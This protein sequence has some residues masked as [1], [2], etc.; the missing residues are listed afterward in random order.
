MKAKKMK[1]PAPRN[2]MTG[3]KFSVTILTDHKNI[4]VKTIFRDPATGEI[5]S[6]GASHSSTWFTHR[7]EHFDTFEVLLRIKQSIT[8]H[9]FYI[10]AQ[11]SDQPEA[12]EGVRANYTDNPAPGV[13]VFFKDAFA[14][15]LT[16]DIDDNDATLIPE[17]MSWETTPVET[18]AEAVWAKVREKS[19]Y[20]KTAGCVWSTSG[21]AGF[22]GK[23]KFHFIVILANPLLQHDRKA[24]LETI[25]DADDAMGGAVQKHYW[26]PR[27][28]K[29]GIEDPL[30]PQVT[31]GI[32]LGDFVW[33]PPTPVPTPSPYAIPYS[34]TNKTTEFGREKL[35]G[36]CAWV[37]ATTSESHDRH[38]NVVKA[39]RLIGGYISG[40]EIANADGYAGLTNAVAGFKDPRHHHKTIAIRIPHGMNTP[41]CSV[42]VWAD[43]VLSKDFDNRELAEMLA[44]FDEGERQLFWDVSWEKSRGSKEQGKVIEGHLTAILG[45]QEVERGRGIYAQSIAT[46]HLSNYRF[47]EDG[48]KGDPVMVHIHTG[49]KVSASSWARM[50]SRDGKIPVPVGEKQP[51]LRKMTD[52]YWDDQLR[53][54]YDAMTFHPASGLDVREGNRLLLNVYRPT[55]SMPSTAV[56][57]SENPFLALL[58]ANLPN[59][60][61]INGQQQW[62]ANVLLDALAWA[63][64]RP[65]E[66]I[67]WAPVMQGWEGCGK[68]VLIPNT[69]RH[70]CGRNVGSS[71]PTALGSDFNGETAN[72][73][74]MIVAEMGERTRHSR[75]D[76]QEHLKEEITDDFRDVIA[77]GFDPKPTR[78]FASWFIMTNHKTS[79]LTNDGKAGRRY[80][81][82]I[83]ALQSQADVDRALPSSMWN[84]FPV[85]RALVS[86]PRASWFG[87]Y[88]V[89]WNQCGGAEQ[90][91]AMLEQ[92][93]LSHVS[94]TAPITSGRVEAEAE[95]M[96][97]LAA[98]IKQNI[99]DGA[100][101]FC[102]GFV[103]DTAITEAAQ[104]DPTL[105][106]A[107]SGKNIG[108][109]MKALGYSNAGRLNA[110]SDDKLL[111]P[112]TGKD[113]G[114]K[115]A[116]YVQ[117]ASLV[118]QS[119][120]Q[121]RC[122]LDAAQVDA[123]REAFGSTMDDTTSTFPAPRMT[124]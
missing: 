117:D 19:G 66:L 31:S 97:P 104:D 63:V 100:V 81:H 44:T 59:S 90:V 103:Y 88:M 22:S 10:H 74:V 122:L 92:R 53:V 120:A 5:D 24:L 36:I 50:P 60:I 47:V 20:T 33:Y 111:F 93:D 6:V 25:P 51:R 28:I 41:L 113:R 91:R 56:W 67:R 76:I 18:L 29:D 112:R 82:L 39:S 110:S 52:V 16:I 86:N 123:R 109:T 32:I 107:A 75:K 7:Q 80:A 94:H 61:E 11:R 49:S 105:K 85:V 78:N 115:V 99:E 95:G 45:E 102:G 64:Q 69:L 55:H 3:N 21:S 119:P 48:G 106:F 101:G 43:E 27:V 121:L 15:C 23:G 89:W 42:T 34:P 83:S 108:T 96:L 40:G 30:A 26:G 38:I 79:M 114:G 62:D 116:L 17:G 71:T 57:Y 98:M 35:A 2:L 84:T 13:Q 12:P 54:S 1:M 46:G 124:H 77:K 65:A 4:Q 9:E 70:C 87:Y 73:T 58:F 68:G 37:A 8:Q 14:H 72:R 118:G